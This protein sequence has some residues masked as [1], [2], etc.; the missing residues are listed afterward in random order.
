MEELFQ[1]LLFLGFYAF[2]S[3]TLMVIGNRLNVANAWLAWVPIASSWVFVKAAGKP[4][5]WL[6][7]LFIPLVNF[8]IALILIFAIPPRLGKSALWG[9]VIFVPLLGVLFYQGYLAFT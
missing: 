1:L 4:G 8:V 6:I 3:Y 5:W 9:L 7:L 2:G